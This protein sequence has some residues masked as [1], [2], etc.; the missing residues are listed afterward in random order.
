M[1]QKKRRSGRR[2][3]LIARQP[4]FIFE[5][6]LCSEIRNNGNE[7]NGKEERKDGRVA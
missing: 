2:G 4:V 5:S 1:K 3:G 6:L 7:N